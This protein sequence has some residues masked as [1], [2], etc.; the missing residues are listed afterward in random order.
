MGLNS[1]TR[2]FVT[3]PEKDGT[4]RVWEIFPEHPHPA[5][6]LVGERAADV[7]GRGD[8]VITRDGAN[9]VIQTTD[10][11]VLTYAPEE[12]GT[13]YNAVLTA[14]LEKHLGRTGLTVIMDTA[15]ELHPS[16]EVPS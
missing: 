3:S 16:S 7:L 13:M 12:W 5:D 14:M 2:I 15:L 6:F 11:D 1:V 9:H 8:A 10:G 4:P